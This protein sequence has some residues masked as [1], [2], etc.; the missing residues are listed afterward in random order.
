M[1]KYTTFSLALLPFQYLKAKSVIL[2]IKSL[3]S[4][5]FAKCFLLHATFFLTSEVASTLWA[6]FYFIFFNKNLD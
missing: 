3:I 2:N 6:N 4:E 5:A 1:K